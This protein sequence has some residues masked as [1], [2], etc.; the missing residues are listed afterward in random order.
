M[1]YYIGTKRAVNAYNKKVGKGMGL[2][3]E[4]MATTMY[5][6]PRKHPTKDLWAIV[7][8]NGYDSLSR[9]LELVQEL[10]EDWH[11]VEES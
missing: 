8:H 5:D 6:R 2:G 10:T 1:S 9:S 3:K 11:E 4:G 7:K